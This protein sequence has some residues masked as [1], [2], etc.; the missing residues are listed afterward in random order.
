MRKL[1][2]AYI[3]PHPPIIV[4]EIGKGEEGP[5][6]RTIEACRQAAKDIASKK[7]ETVIIIT[8]HGPAFKDAVSISV[9]E[10]LTGSFKNFRRPD[11]KLDFQNDT[12]L[13]AKIVDNCQR[14]GVAVA[15]LNSQ[16][17][18]RCE[19]DSELDHGAMVPLYFIAK[20]YSG[21]KLV[22]IC[23]GFLSLEELFTFGAAINN[24]IKESGQSVVIV[25]SGDLSHKL[26]DDG[27][28]G[29]NK[30]GSE[31]DE[32]FIKLLGQ[33]EFND[34]ISMDEELV[35]EAA[36]CGLRPFTIL[37]GAL[38]DYKVKPQILS[39][40]GPFGVGYGVAIINVIGR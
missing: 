34:I 16:L 20:E 18:S 4:P 8:P 37:F 36:Q 22:H 15:E 7:P 38:N 3:F 6:S 39:Y 30:H 13:V 23:M 27:P 11:V 26:S 32:L 21:F 10:E 40:E 25:A 29:Y 14:D 19:I 31:F 28:Y 33:G 9:K 24:A 35:E 17:T 5:A 12:K 2:S 1:L